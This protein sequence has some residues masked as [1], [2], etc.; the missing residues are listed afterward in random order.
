MYLAEDYIGS[1]E[2]DAVALVLQDMRWPGRVGGA[3]GTEQEIDPSGWQIIWSAVQAKVAEWGFTADPI[4]TATAL[5]DRGYR[6]APGGPPGA[7]PGGVP[8]YLQVAQAVGVAVSEVLRM[9]QGVAVGDTTA[10]RWAKERGISI[11]R[12]PIT[13][14]IRFALPREE[15]RSTVQ[16]IWESVKVSLPV[17]LIGGA[18]LYAVARARR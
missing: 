18:I 2:A 16:Q 15:D 17:L 10:E 7:T 14:E 9:Q 13:G 11:Y 12:D 8:W 5:T 1:N 3:T 4:K 6:L